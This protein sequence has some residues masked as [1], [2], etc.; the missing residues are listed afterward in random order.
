MLSME[1]KTRVPV[2]IIFIQ[3]YIE[4]LSIEEGQKNILKYIMNRKAKLPLI[5][6]DTIVYVEN[7]K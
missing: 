6:D 4:D 7:A 5:V 3:A 2:I 1:F